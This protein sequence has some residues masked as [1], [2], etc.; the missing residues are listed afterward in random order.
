[1]RP[2]F[3]LS[4]PRSGSTLLARL[5]ASHPEVAAPATEPWILIPPFFARR[6]R[7][8]HSALYGHGALATAMAENEA[9]D[10]GGAGSALSEATRLWATAWY[11]A[12]SDI[13]AKVVIDK[14]PRYHLIL[15]SLVEAFPD[16]QF[17]FL[18]RNPLAVAASISTTWN[19]S[20]WAFAGSWVD[21]YWG[22]S[23]LVRT[24]RR[25]DINSLSLNYESVI[26][27]P[28]QELSLVYEWLDLSPHE[29]TLASNR[30]VYRIGDVRAARSTKVDAGRG[31]H[32][33]M[34]YQSRH[35]RRWA[36]G[37]LKW[38][39]EERLGLI[40]YS[41]NELL[42]SLYSLETS[43]IGNDVRQST[44]DFGRATRRLFAPSVLAATRT[45]RDQAAL[46]VW[47]YGRRQPWRDWASRN[48]RGK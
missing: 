17:I 32:W 43:H 23:E 20:A 14:T 6:A 8:V 36:G 22:F 42:D 46:A 10:G 29:A 19:S 35:R 9:G 48:L 18:W 41:Q 12:T 47:R 30:P 44:V 40:G 11:E 13:S 31:T 3:L 33:A 21:L 28:T 7:G 15:E 37:Y 38:I 45:L 39:G 34:Q 26:A 25:T 2:V 27:N 24:Y 5:L 4:L 16:A 1:M